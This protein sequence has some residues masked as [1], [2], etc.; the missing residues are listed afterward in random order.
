[1]GD[2]N[3]GLWSIPV[4]T[5]GAAVSTPVQTGKRVPPKTPVKMTGTHRPPKI[6]AALS[7]RRG[8]PAQKMPSNYVS[9][10]PPVV[11]S[12]ESSE[13]EI[14]QDARHVFKTA[15]TSFFKVIR[16]LAYEHD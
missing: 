10:K 5:S 4:S 16:E 15:C 14:S 1:M 13:E 2:R 3:W 9:F 12:D 7:R 11:E 8:P 6:P